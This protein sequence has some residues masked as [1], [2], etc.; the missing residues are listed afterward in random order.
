MNIQ[1]NDKS[2]ADIFTALFQHI[3]CFTEHINIMFQQDKLYI[4]ALDNSRVSIFEIHIPTAWFDKYTISGEG[5]ITLGINSMLFYKVLTTRETGQSIEIDH[6]EEES[7]RISA[8]FTANAGSTVKA[9]VFDKH[10][11]IPLVDIDCETMH[12]PAIDHQAEFSMAS[13]TFSSLI[14]QLQM[15][16]DTVQIQ[17]SEDK[18]QLCAKSVEAGNMSVDIPID[19]LSEFSIDEGETMNLSFSL[20]QLHHICQYSKIA[21]EIVLKLSNSYPICIQ[22][23]FD[24]NV[25]SREENGQDHADV[26]PNKANITFYLAPKMTDD[27]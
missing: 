3:K 2:K 1:I 12:I 17:C 11:K 7:D 8:H 19:D 27:N 5:G 4:Q 25:S 15:F 23:V 18:I 20:M 13:S 14:N 9:G 22:Y 21:K 16:S 6:T 10:F 24:Q 26:E